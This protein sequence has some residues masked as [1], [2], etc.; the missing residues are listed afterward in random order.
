MEQV[1]HR[2][3]GP[4]A[5]GGKTRDADTGT[6]QIVE[7]GGTER[8]RL[9]QQPHVPGHDLDREEERL[10]VDLG[11]GVG[12]TEGVGPDHSD[13]RIAHRRQQAS[14]ELGALGAGV[15]ESGGEDQGRTDTGVDAVFDDRRH[16]RRRHGDDRKIRCRLDVSNPSVGVDPED[17]VGLG[18]HE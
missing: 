4:V 2:D 15:G 17:G 8:A 10:E 12:E 7:H 11:I 1:V 5:Q 16:R 13:P 14:F 9:R 18:V 6:G 3:V